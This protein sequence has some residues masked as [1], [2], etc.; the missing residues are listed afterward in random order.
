MAT[1]SIWRS[2]TL[3]GA[4]MALDTPGLYCRGRK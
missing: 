2:D 3:Q 4:E 1:L